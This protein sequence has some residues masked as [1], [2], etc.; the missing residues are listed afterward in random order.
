M[1]VAMP[2]KSRGLTY[3]FSGQNFQFAMQT[4][5][6]ILFSVTMRWILCFLANDAYSGFDP[7]RAPR[8]ARVIS[9][10]HTQF[11]NFAIFNLPFDRRKNSNSVI[12]PKRSSNPPSLWNISVL[13]MNGPCRMLQLCIVVSSSTEPLDSTGRKFFSCIFRTG[14][15]FL[16]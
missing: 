3:G 6:S 9:G 11:A 7:S 2:G 5:H 13:I 8:S 16:M 1:G 4:V 12:L 15:V 10:V 14:P